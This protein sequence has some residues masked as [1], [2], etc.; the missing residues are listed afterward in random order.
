MIKGIGGSGRY[1][2][3][4]GGMT[5]VPYIN[6]SSGSMGNPMQ[7]MMRVSGSDVQVF[8]GT[9]WLNMGSSFANVGLTSEAETLLDWAR[10]Q[11][12]AQQLYESMAKD[13]PAVKIALEN[14]EKAKQQLRVTAE[15][16]K[17]REYSESEQVQASP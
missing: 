6:M 10:D 16:S 5:N 2:T 12:S 4:S 11:R 14:L 8:D 17:Q 1:M 13:H 15:L 9:S 7:G 3:V